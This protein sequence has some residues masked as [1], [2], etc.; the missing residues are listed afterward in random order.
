MTAAAASASS[1][2]TMGVGDEVFAVDVKYVSEILDHR[3]AAH[4]PHAPPYLVGVI[5][6]RG[7]TVPV[8]DLRLKLGLAQGSVSENTRILVLEIDLEDRRLTIGLLVDR[9]FEVAE[10]DAGGLDGAPDVGVRWKSEYIRGIGR[11]R[12][13]FVI[14]FDMERLFSSEE[15]ASLQAVP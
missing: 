7:Q 5:D 15:M 3:P 8:V 1:Y 13:S 14:I 2:V 6:V 11:L 10:F 4:L 9:V 12:G